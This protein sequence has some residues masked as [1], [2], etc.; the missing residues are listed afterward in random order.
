MTCIVDGCKQVAQKV[1]KKCTTHS[2]PKACK[3]CNPE[4]SVT[5]TNDGPDSCMVNVDVQ[6]AQQLQQQHGVVPV[7]PAGTGTGASAMNTGGL[8][9]KNVLNVV[10]SPA[11]GTTAMGTD[12]SKGMAGPQGSNIII[13]QNIIS[14]STAQMT[15]ATEASMGKSVLDATVA[16]PCVEGSSVVDAGHPSH[17]YDDSVGQAVTAKHHPSP[18]DS[19]VITSI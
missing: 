1:G 11:M 15:A 14:S 16:Q 7:V 3:P 4:P 13:A 5:T 8:F 10:K 6:A 18:V 9:D 12:I 19:Q 2:E 17:L